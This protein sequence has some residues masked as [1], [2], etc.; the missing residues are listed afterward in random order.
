MTRL[1]IR[2]FARYHHLDAFFDVPTD[3]SAEAVERL[4]ALHYGASDAIDMTRIVQALTR[5]EDAELIMKAANAMP[6]TA[7][8]Q[9]FVAANESAYDGFLRLAGIDPAKWREVKDEEA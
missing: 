1:I 5:I 4:C 2:R 3:D 8:G 7:W 9:G 6:T